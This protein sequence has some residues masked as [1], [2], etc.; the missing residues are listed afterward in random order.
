MADA[1]LALGTNLGDREGRLA[2]ALDLLAGTDGIVVVK[3]SRVY[4]SAPWG[5]ADQPDFLNVCVH[6]DTLLS[7]EGLLHA[8]KQVEAAIGRQQRQRW[9][10]REIDIDILL[11]AGV[12]IDTPK[13]TIPHSRMAER[14]FVMEPLA[15]IAPDWDIDGVSV[16]DLARYLRVDAVDQTCKPDEKATQ[17]VMQLR[18]LLK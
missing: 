8:C 13:L 9:G 6:I 12:D 18:G 5:V 2:A 1:F 3:M 15:E 10:P 7:P 14:R 11:M 17:R 4:W 16:S